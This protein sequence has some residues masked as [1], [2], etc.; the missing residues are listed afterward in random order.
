MV[1]VGPAGNA[2]TL[3]PAGTTHSGKV[4]VEDNA[5]GVALCLAHGIAW[6]VV[7][8]EI[9][10]VLLSQGVQLIADRIKHHGTEGGKLLILVLNHLGTFGIVTQKAQVFLELHIVYALPPYMLPFAQVNIDAGALTLPAERNNV[11]HMF[12]I[13][14]PH[15]EHLAHV[16]AEHAYLQLSRATLP[17]RI[18]IA[19]AF[20]ADIAG[21][22]LDFAEDIGH[23][24]AF[25]ARVV[26][27]GGIYHIQLQQLVAR[28]LQLVV[29]VRAHT[30]LLDRDGKRD[31]TT[32]HF[33]LGKEPWRS[34][35]G[36][37]ALLQVFVNL[38]LQ[39]VHQLHHHIG[40]HGSEI[41]PYLAI[42]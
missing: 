23:H 19:D 5:V 4:D 3:L 6:D 11:P 38:L 17:A 9:Y 30:Q 36:A 18:I 22:E 13:S 42:Y 8:R 35:I 31:R 41:A 28:L 24:D 27:L 39:G 37:L 10:L 25:L 40:L 1:Q 2:L 32:A 7:E 21:G 14:A 12:H 29:G 16:L 26:V 20:L 34:H 33:L 15:V